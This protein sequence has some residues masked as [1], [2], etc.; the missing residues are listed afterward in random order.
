MIGT[1]LNTAAILVGGTVG[2]TVAREI[3]LTTQQWLKFALG[4]FIVYAGLSTAWGALSGSF[5]QSTAFA[6]SHT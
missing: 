4:A 6:L 5:D 1:I 3:S 2:L